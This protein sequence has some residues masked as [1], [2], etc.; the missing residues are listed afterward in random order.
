MGISSLADR[1]SDLCSKLFARISNDELHAL[2]YLLP[3]KRDTELINRLRS[4]DI[5]F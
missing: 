4:A 1:R 3:T 2:H 5:T